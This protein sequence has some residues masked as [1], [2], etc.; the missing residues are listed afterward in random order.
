MKFEEPISGRRTRVTLVILSLS[1]L[2][3]MES[4]TLSLAKALARDYEVRI[5]LLADDGADVPIDHV[6]VESW[7][8][9]IPDWKRAVTLT[10]AFSHRND[11]NGDVIILCGVWT[12]IPM[13]MALPK[14][15]LAHTLI[16]EHSFDKGKVASCKRLAV[17]EAAARRYYHR[18][19][20]T[21]TVSESVRH[22]MREA[23]FQDRIEVIPNI[24][25]EFD[26][27]FAEEI[28]S[29]RLVTVGSL[30]RTK[31]QGLALRTLALLP[32]QYSL[33]VVGDGPERRALERLANDLGI[34]ERVNFRGYV[35]NPAEFYSQAQIVV[36]PSLGET[37]GLVLY[38]AASFG[39]PVVAADRSVMAKVIPEFVPGKVAEPHPEAFA[40][41]ILSLEATPLSQRVFTDAAS[42]RRAASRNIVKDWGSLI[43]DAMRSNSEM[44]PRV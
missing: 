29:G 31:N 2:L 16:A 5:V 37:Y 36:H 26:S 9:R 34:T 17:M 15:L 28:C 40:S 22:D 24:V 44:M 39:K 12:A 1:P 3:G 13:L 18:A 7:G 38:E 11:P 8:G 27:H 14:K 20:A 33:D 6:T 35:E 42:R 43:G 41:A 25:R 23:G 21:V 10:R 4:A 30:T 19:F 32:E